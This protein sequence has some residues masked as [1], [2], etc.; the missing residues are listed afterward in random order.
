MMETDM[1]KCHSH[2][3]LS[4]YSLGHLW[5]TRERD[6]GRCV[7]K[8]GN[9]LSVGPLL[10]TPQA[11]GGLKNNSLWLD[12]WQLQYLFATPVE[13]E[14]WCRRCEVKGETESM[15]GKMEK[16]KGF[17]AAGERRG[18]RV[19]LMHKDMA[20]WGRTAWRMAGRH[21]PDASIATETCCIKAS[22]WIKG[23]IGLKSNFLIA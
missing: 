11:H 23:D 7:T 19:T 13:E 14:T 3:L 6:G 18:A 22:L 17:M 10:A 15:K 5:K 20:A 1:Q 9:A 8:N 21:S 4:K 16:V 12:D 2:H